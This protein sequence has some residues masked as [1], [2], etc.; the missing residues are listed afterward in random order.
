[1]VQFEIN[2][3]ITLDFNTFL[4][5]S[6]YVDSIKCSS[7]VLDG[8]P[9][10]RKNKDFI[11]SFVR[12]IFGNFVNTMCG[13]YKEGTGRCDA[14]GPFPSAKSTG[15]RKYNTFLFVLLDLLESFKSFEL[16]K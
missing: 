15:E 9:C 14:V 5:S 6:S 3:I 4:F 1:M 16:P 11:L 13:E 8:V 10:L 12:E 2:A 7:D